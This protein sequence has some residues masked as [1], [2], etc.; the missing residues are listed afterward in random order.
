MPNLST[1]DH[2]RSSPS[3][4]TGARHHDHCKSAPPLITGTMVS[5]IKTGR[6]KTT[7]SGNVLSTSEACP[8]I[9][10]TPL[11]FTD[12]TQPPDDTQTVVE[13]TQQGGVGR[14]RL[15]RVRGRTLGKGVQKKNS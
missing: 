7:T 10:G 15:I 14:K 12:E 9:I 1:A 8:A 13:K 3:L 5:G 11:M 2:R 6:R 4:A